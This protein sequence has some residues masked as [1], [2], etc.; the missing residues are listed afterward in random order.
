MQGYRDTSPKHFT[1]LQFSLPI[2]KLGAWSLGAVNTFTPH[3]LPAH[4]LNMGLSL[5]AL[6]SEEV[7]CGP[8]SPEAPSPVSC[9]DP[10][11]VP[12][13]T[14]QRVMD[15]DF[16]HHCVNAPC[17]SCP[18][19]PKPPCPSLYKTEQRQ[20]TVTLPWK[21]SYSSSVLFPGL[22]PA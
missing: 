12:E 21:T 14:R 19:G 2:A 5:S 6:S 18:T 16:S 4:P 10:P 9:S 15:P 7:Q 20:P 8:T 3:E 1:S 22:P 13:G 17:H 11:A